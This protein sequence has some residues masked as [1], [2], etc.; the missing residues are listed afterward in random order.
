MG[1]FV[2]SPMTGSDFQKQGSIPE[3]GKGR[4][5]KTGCPVFDEYSRTPSPNSVKEKFIEGEIPAPSGEYDHF[6]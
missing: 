2:D 5:N 6:D 1:E 4:Y 3:G